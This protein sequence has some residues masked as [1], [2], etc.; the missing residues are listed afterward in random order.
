MTS[1]GFEN[2]AHGTRKKNSITAT[3]GRLKTMTKRNEDY[4]KFKAKSVETGNWVFGSVVQTAAGC[5]MVRDPEEYGPGFFK[6][7]EVDPETVCMYVR[8]KDDEGNEIYEGDIFE[9]LWLWHSENEP[10]ETLSGPVSW[11]SQGAMVTLPKGDHAVA[12]VCNI[13]DFETKLVRGSIHDNPPEQEKRRAQ[14]AIDGDTL[15]TFSKL[16]EFMKNCTKELA[17]LKNL[18]EALAE[19]Y[20]DENKN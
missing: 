12:T 8:A 4:V 2:S 13:H 7:V 9:G 5:W 10:P 6:Y 17:A 14:V 16:H 18:T 19:R 20:N 1:T 3:A 15:N 11:D